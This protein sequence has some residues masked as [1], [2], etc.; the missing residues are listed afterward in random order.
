MN[1]ERDK[2]LTEAM[3]EC[4]HEIHGRAMGGVIRCSKCQEIMVIDD[5]DF[6]VTRVTNSNFSTWTGFGKLWEWS[7]QQPWWTDD[8]FLYHYPV[9]P[10]GMLIN[11]GRFAD[12]V[13][14]FLKRKETE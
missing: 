13:Y 6:L 10:R 9:G 11:P 4:W 8:N 3:G 14:A 1:L 2:A 12:A 7:I 5:H